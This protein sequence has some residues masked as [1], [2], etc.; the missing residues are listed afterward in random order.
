MNA[1]TA[2][3]DTTAPVELY[4]ESKLKG[5][6][7]IIVWVIVVSLVITAAVGIATLLSGEMGETQS[8]VLI[9][10]LAIAGFSVTALCHLAVINR[11][12]R[13]VGWAGIVSSALGLVAAL[14]LIWRS[15]EYEENYSQGLWDFVNKAFV[16]LLICALSFAHANLMLL[17]AHSRRRWMRMALG[18]NLILITLVAVMVIPAVVSNGEFPSALI[19]DTYWRLFGVVAI[20][21][22][23]GTIALPVTTLIMRRQ[24]DDDVEAHAMVSPAG[25]AAA[26][27]VTVTLPAELSARVIERAA[28]AGAT[29]A[30]FV[31]DTVTKALAQSD[32]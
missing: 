9:T 22:A 1:D 10:T 21:D 19:A 3:A 26:S 25:T 24:H 12:V 4:D 6:R 14:M 2:T 13:V 23:L 5:L 30:Q 28:A 29:P 8:K 11:D 32:S 7:R 18:A 20:L 15:W 16:V 17:L 27:A 31:T